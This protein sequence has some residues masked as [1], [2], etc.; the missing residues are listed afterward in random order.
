M[1]KVVISLGGSV[2]VPDEVDYKFLKKFSKVISNFSK[3]NKVVII[4]GGGSTARDYIEPLTMSKLGDK[5]YSLVGIAATKL[6]ARLVASFFQKTKKVPESIEE[7]K[8]R[9]KKFNVVVSGA[10]GVQTNMTSDG[11]AAQVAEA[12]NAD[13]FVNITNVKGLYTKHPKLKGAKF[14]PE[15]SYSE[16]LE[17]AN[18]IKYKAGQHFV[19][20]K[21]AA[22]II[23]K[24]KIKTYIVSKNINNLKKVL[25]EKKFTGTLISSS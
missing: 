22:R 9:L 5:M 12:I 8:R 6:N 3:K 13:F 15:I 10:L 20:D 23:K 1:K 2:I 11:N 7:I 14:I 19:L 17:R 25:N 21:P 4:T 24:A 16:F 18:K